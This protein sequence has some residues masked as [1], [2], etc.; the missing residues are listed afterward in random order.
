MDTA[1]S[2]AGPAT[3]ILRDI[4]LSSETVNLHA[5]LLAM[6]DARRVDTLLIE[7][8]LSSSAPHIRAVAA[9][10]VGQAGAASRAARLAALLDDADFDVAASAAFSLGLLRDSTTIQALATALRSERGVVALEASWALGEIGAPARGEIEAA[11]ADTARVRH[12]PELLRAAAKLRPVPVGLIAPFLGGADSIRAAA[13]YALSRSRPPS[14][15]RHLI[16]VVGDSAWAPATVESG[17]EIALA[18]EILASAARGL[19]ASAA[20]DSLRDAALAALGRLVRHSHPHVRINAIR[21]LG[22]FGTAARE[23]IVSR[24]SDTDANVRI[25]VAQST[26]TVLGSAAGEWD[27][28]WQADTGTA[29]RASLLAS[30]AQG[31]NAD[32][33]LRLGAPWAEA[34]DWRHRSAY[35]SALAASLRGPRRDAALEA[36]R[37]LPDARVR[38]ATLDALADSTAPAS[39]RRR[40][41]ETA[42]TDDD[43]FVRAGAIGA[44]TQRATAKDLPAILAAY[45]KALTDSVN[46]AR[47]AALSGLGAVWRRDSVAVSPAMQSRLR[48]LTP[49]ADPLERTAVRGVS[50]LSHWPGPEGTPRPIEWYEDKVRTLVEPTLNGKALT[51]EIVTERGALV[52][53]L[54]SAIAPLTVHNFVTLAN[55][56]YYSGTRFHR[57]VPNFVVQDGD[58]RGDG[59]G[60]PGYAI[61]DELNRMR[62]RRGTLGMALSGPHTGGS[63]YFLTHSPQPHLDGH[64]TVFGQLVSGWP[65]LDAI[66]QGDV[67]QRVDIRW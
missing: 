22:T 9:L 50:P 34:G 67:I 8:A 43:A 61:R 30:A 16:G 35:A 38:A 39:W 62:Y 54:A 63:Q 18:I 27:R 2:E 49:P 33:V 59:N 57:V 25:T 37:R 51:A 14:A 26:G 3:A 65:V 1:E 17:P 64:Y 13:T 58:P 10:A 40:L 5:R 6:L 7:E 15:V 55:A 46:E 23:A 24:A 53:E 66:V 48:S 11:L 45:E 47:L 44:I 32:H 20:G 31:R 36:L 4:E 28:L 60:G 21:S 56:G 29:Y 42:A 19:A 12:I 41:L 52:V